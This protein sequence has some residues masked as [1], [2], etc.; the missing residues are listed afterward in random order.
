M[1]DFERFGIP[2][3]EHSTHDMATRSISHPLL[4]TACPLISFW[5][6]KYGLHSTILQHHSLINSVLVRFGR[7]KFQEALKISNRGETIDID[8]PN[9]KFMAFD[10][11]NHNGTYEQRYSLLGMNTS[12]TQLMMASNSYF[13]RNEAAS[14]SIEIF[15]NSAQTNMYR[16][17]SLG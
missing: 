14:F 7:D 6:E 8:W 11:P 16:N 2:T 1:M 3:P 4:S 10:V 17:G 9:F 12:T 13:Q 5:M 15:G